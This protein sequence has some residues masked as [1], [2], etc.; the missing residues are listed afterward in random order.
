MLL[1]NQALS[2]LIY[3]YLSVLNLALICCIYLNIYIYVY[4]IETHS[5]DIKRKYHKIIWDAFVYII[6][7]FQGNNLPIQW[8]NQI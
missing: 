8:N 4:D 1:L 2:L 3:K 7:P 5:N 6:K